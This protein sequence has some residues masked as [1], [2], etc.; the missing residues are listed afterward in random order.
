[1]YMGWAYFERYTG[2]ID[3]F[4]RKIQISIRRMTS[5]Q[6]KIQDELRD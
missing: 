2:I 4:R 5:F 1:M 3:I 6:M